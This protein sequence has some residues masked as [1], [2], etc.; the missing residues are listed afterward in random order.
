MPNAEIRNITG[1]TIERFRGGQGGGAP[2][3]TNEE[4]TLKFH[5]YPS[6]P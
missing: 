2:A 1:V 3:Q 5:L 6:H 4:A